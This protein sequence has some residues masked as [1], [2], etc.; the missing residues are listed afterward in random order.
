MKSAGDWLP[1]APT[2][3]LARA[4]WQR[5]LRDQRTVELARLAGPE[6]G[7]EYSEA[8]LDLLEFWQKWEDQLSPEQCRLLAKVASL[9]GYPE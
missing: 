3:E 1:S 8:E 9:F 7:R 5:M 6:L 2:D 4:R